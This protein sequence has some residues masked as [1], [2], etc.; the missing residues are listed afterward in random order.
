MPTPRYK[1]S[2][3]EDEE[4]QFRQ[5][6]DGYAAATG[7]DADP[8]AEGHN[9]DYRGYWK[10]NP[11][12]EVS[13]G[14]HLPDTYKMPGHETFSTESK[15]FVDQETT[16]AGTWN[17]DTYV[18]AQ[19][20]TP[21]PDED[22]KELQAIK[23]TNAATLKS[24]TDYI[25]EQYEYKKQQEDE[26]RRQEEGNELA[27][28]WTGAAELGAAI[29][30]M[31]GVGSFGASNQQY[32]S[33]SQ[34]W[35]KKADQDI[36]DHRKRRDDLKNTLDRLNLQLQ[37]LKGAQNIQEIQTA[38][39]MRKE[40]EAKE[41]SDRDEAFRREQFEWQKEKATKA[42]EAQ[43]AAQARQ[44]KATDADIAQGWA[45][46]NQTKDAYKTQMLANGWVPDKSAPGGFRYDPTE[47]KKY[48]VTASTTVKNSGKD[49]YKISIIDAD[50]NVNI[51]DLGSEKQKEELL[52]IAKQAIKSDLSEQQYKQFEAS[53]NMAEDDEDKES[54]LKEWI[55]RS[56]KMEEA[57]KNY[58]PNYKGN[59]GAIRGFTGGT[60]S[61]DDFLSALNG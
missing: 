41:K 30:N 3:T 34:D 43:A 18:P 37:E 17:G 52:S 5:W 56:P 53:L 61:G 33:Y 28:R 25:N 4:K 24:F 27:A 8:D 20:T 45:R 42:E 12:A 39:Q 7:N 51:A 9:Y 35:M 58:D 15:Y 50:G 40:K 16:P 32:H 60:M 48:G 22:A 47:A 46:I 29:A 59:H 38:R 11:T 49:G 6:Y 44:D 55:G 21:D 57:L 26:M 31:I 13:A 36:K 2:L 14:M 23:D 10:E 1:T 19:R 54:I